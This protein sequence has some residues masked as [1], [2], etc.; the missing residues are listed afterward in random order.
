MGE[1]TRLQQIVWNIVG[2]AIK[3][4]PCGGTIE[5]ELR[6][7]EGEAAIEVRD[8]ATVSTPPSSPTSST[9]S[10]SRADATVDWVSDWRSLGASSICT[11]ERSRRIAKASAPGPRSP[12][13][14]PSRVT[15]ETANSSKS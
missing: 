5:V 1:M 8:T 2:N 14:C 4:T 7:E 3:H 15:H 12:S 9:P 10:G 11:A 6:A 13:A